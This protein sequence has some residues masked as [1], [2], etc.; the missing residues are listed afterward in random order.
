MKHFWLVWKTHLK[1]TFGLSYIKYLFRKNRRKFIRQAVFFPLILLALLPVLTLITKLFQAIFSIVHPIGQD[2]VVVALA[3][4]FTQSLS[5]VF[6]FFYLMSNFYFASDLDM[7]LPLPIR[8]S[9]ILG[10]KFLT[11]VISEYII[12]IPVVLPAFWV[13][14][15]AAPPA[16][17][18]PAAVLVTLLLPVIPLAVAAVFV[19]I[20][21]RVTNV[22]KSRGLLRIAGAFIGVLLYAGIQWFQFRF[23]NNDTGQLTSLV[24][25]PNGLVGMITRKFPPSLWAAQGL[26]KFPSS[27]GLYYLGLFLG[28][29][30]AATVFLF[31]LADRIFYKGL[32]G[33]NEVSAKKRKYVA[34][35]KTFQSRAVF[36]ALFLREWRNLVRSASFLTP[37]LVNIVILPIAFVFPFFSAGKGRLI[38][39]AQVQGDTWLQ[40]LAVFAVTGLVMITSAAN[41]I[42]S[43]GLSRE[44]KTFWL[45]KTIPA[46]PFLQ[47]MAKFALALVVPIVLTVAAIA[48]ELFILHF[49]PVRL[50]Q[51]AVL[52]LL[53]S[54]MA[55]SFSL[56]IDML[57]PKLNWT[58]PQQVMKRNFNAIASMFCSM[59]FVGVGAGLVIFLKSRTDISPAMAFTLLTVLFAV[60]AGAFFWL[61][62]AKANSRYQKIDV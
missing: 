14:S 50:L 40:Y 25:S 1:Q 15:A 56:F 30:L 28:V 6:G 8:P 13:Y 38:T 55:V 35:S 32:I 34:T 5:L 9:V 29:S 57:N 33:G 31:L 43:T 18:W 7:L 3:F 52:P 45:S 47:V 20:L 61:L 39:V 48:G 36:T 51:Q 26:I 49:P 10:S 16:I 46:P 37:A 58:D 21:M 27:E 53:G 4:V 22:S 23:R 44:G 2:A 42:A 60:L 24:T 17:F 41:S 59:A 12:A 54:A 62:S 11:V 19:V